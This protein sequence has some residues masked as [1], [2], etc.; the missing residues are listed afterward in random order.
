MAL[1]FGAHPAEYLDNDSGEQST[2][3]GKFV[4]ELDSTRRPHFEQ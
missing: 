3:S 2:P 4:G 1:L